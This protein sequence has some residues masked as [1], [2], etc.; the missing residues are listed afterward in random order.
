M[1]N[2]DALLRAL[3]VDLVDVTQ[4]FKLLRVNCKYLL[5][6]DKEPPTTMPSA[7]VQ[8]VKKYYADRK[9]KQPGYKYSAAMKDARASYKSAKAGKSKSAK[10]DE[11]DEKAPPKKAKAKRK[12]KPKAPKR[13]PRDVAEPEAPAK[14]KKKAK[15][16]RPGVPKDFT[17]LN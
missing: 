8:H 5:P 9:K 3:V 16:K 7:W 6:I 17:N 1:P 13:P 11:V 2:V 4:H 15:R 14:K 12:R 10:G